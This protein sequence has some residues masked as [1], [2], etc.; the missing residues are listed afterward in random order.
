MPVGHLLVGV[1][2]A[3]DGTLGEAL[4]N[5]HHADWKTICC[6]AAG[7]RQGRLSAAVKGPGVTVN[8]RHGVYGFPDRGSGLTHLS[9]GS[10]LLLCHGVDRLSCLYGRRHN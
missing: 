4:S 8:S 5:N 3:K 9:S 6:E 10:G 7:Y 1:T 2:N